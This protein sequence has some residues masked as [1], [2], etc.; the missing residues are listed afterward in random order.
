MQNMAASTVVTGGVSPRDGS[1]REKLTAK[2][3]FTPS[4]MVGLS[5]GTIIDYLRHHQTVSVADLVEF[6]GVTA[7]AVRQRLGRLMEQGFVTRRTTQAEPAGRRKVER[8]PAKTMRPRRGRPTHR[9]SL[10]REGKRTAGSNYQD[11]AN[12]LWLEI[13]AI[14]NLEVRRG[15]LR[16]IVTRLLD[17][18]REQVQGTTLRERMNSLVALW[19]SRDIPFEVHGPLETDGDTEA[20]A[21]PGQRLTLTAF[22]CPYPDLAEQDRMVCALEKMLFSEMLGQKLQLTACRLDGDV[23]CA[24]TAQEGTDGKYTNKENMH[25]SAM[26]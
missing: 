1:L 21:L 15:L 3:K 24:F 9:Y 25:D 5:D 19:E 14:P 23:C 4:S 8:L 13:R 10:T 7:T 18:Y 16:R 17:N 26:D 11:L 2:D 22:A 6:T 20:A 12:A